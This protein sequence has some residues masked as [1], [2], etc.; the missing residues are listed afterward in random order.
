[1]ILD[2]YETRGHALAV[3]IEPVDPVRGGRPSHPVRIAVEGLLPPRF[4]RHDSRR[5]ALRVQPG[6][7]EEID[8]RIDERRRRYVPRR[9]RL[10]LAVLPQT[11]R[12]ALF[13]GAGYDYVPRTT[14]LR[15]RVTRAGE[16]LR[17]A[18]V[19]ARLPG[20]DTLVGRAHGDDRGEFLLLIAPEAAPFAELTDPLQVAVSVFGPAT[21]PVPDPPG[22]ELEDPYWDLPLEPLAAPGGPDPIADGETLPA[23]YVATDD[24]PRVI[25]FR[26]GRTL[27]S[28]D[29]IADFEF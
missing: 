29:G 20:T 23:G 1:M 11:R 12:P 5:H 8:L 24:S 4:E 7:A 14:G 21:A 19:E 6:L 9:L 13:P 3:G 16:P 10:D 26:L 18:R 15:G 2:G 25:A 27:S 28:R 22:I 17:W